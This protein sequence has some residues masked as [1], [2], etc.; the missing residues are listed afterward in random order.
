MTDATVHISEVPSKVAKKYKRAIDIHWQDWCSKNIDYCNKHY[1]GT[2]SKER[3]KV[4]LQHNTSTLAHMRTVLPKY[5]S[6]T[7]IDIPKDFRKFSTDL[8]GKKISGSKASA[9][10]YQYWNH[11]RLATYYNGG[12]D[13]GHDDELCLRH[14]NEAL[15]LLPQLQR[16]EIP[17]YEELLARAL[18]ALAQLNMK[19]YEAALLEYRVVFASIRLLDDSGRIK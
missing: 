16:N 8:M 3:G 9:A 1:D 6:K 18:R 13:W 11:Q 4:V 7:I 5:Q 14:A 2:Q 12:K 10:V 15:S 17:H 19:Y